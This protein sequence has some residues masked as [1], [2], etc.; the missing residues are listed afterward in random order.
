M[1][2]SSSQD[3]GFLVDNLSIKETQLGADGKLSPG[4][5]DSLISDARALYAHPGLTPQQR[6]NIEVKIAQYNAAKQK[7]SLATNNDI[8]R[9]NRDVKDDMAKII[10][11]Y[12]NDPAKFLAAKSALLTAKIDQL[13]SSI[14]QIETSGDDATAHR[15]ELTTSL[16]DYQDVAQALEDVKKGGTG[17]NYA[18]Y[19]TTNS[20]G[21]IVDMDIARVGSKTGYMPTNGT[22]SGLPVYGKPNKFDNGKPTFQ[23][24]NQ[25]FVQSD[26]LTTSP[27][28]VTQQKVLVA[29]GGGRGGITVNGGNVAID[30][31]QVRTQG[32]LR[33]GSWA[34]GEKGIYQVQ[35]DGSYKKY[36]NADK[37]KLGISDG[38]IISIPR[39]MEQGIIPQVKETIDSSMPVPPPQPSV[40]QVAPATTPGAATSTQAAPT[41]GGSPKTPA[42]TVRA[43]QD[44]SGTAAAT[45]TPAKGFFARLFGQ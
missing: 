2:K 19:L 27:D 34:Q 4:D 8:S 23:F 24:G 1:R 11:R 38:D 39:S 5:Y 40:P 44:A 21:E 9:L 43:P 37:A 35:P 25:N 31:S 29:G 12:G 10:Q 3:Y 22:Y 33:P 26:T 42:P 14:N 28:G 45:S 13:S 41:A 16:Q 36:I 15:N 6:S 32:A 17:S 30:P 20:R 18:T 7:D